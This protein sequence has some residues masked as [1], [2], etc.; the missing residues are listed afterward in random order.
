MKKRAPEKNEVSMIG[1]SAAE[2]LALD[3][4]RGQIGGRAIDA[5]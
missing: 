2:Y 3:V 4:A 5:G 1:P